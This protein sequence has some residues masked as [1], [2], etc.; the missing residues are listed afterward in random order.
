[1]NCSISLSKKYEKKFEMQMLKGI[2]K[3]LKPKLNQKGFNVS[4]YIP[5]GTNL[6]PYSIRR[7]KERK[8]N[9]NR[10]NS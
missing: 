2:R 3:E 10:R 4:E 5:Y 9:I 7:M 1:I 6:L 8:R